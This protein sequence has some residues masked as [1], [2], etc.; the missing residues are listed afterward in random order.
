MSGEAQESVEGT[1][2]WG[3]LAHLLYLLVGGL[4]VFAFAWSLEPALEDQKEGLCRGL[5]PE[6]RELETPALV[7]QDLEGGSH[8]L[9]DLRGKFV[10]LNFW[11]TWCGPCVEE[12]PA[13]ARLAERM[14]ERDD[15]VVV[16]VSVDE[17]PEDIPPFLKQ[18][19]LGEVP[20]QV[21]WDPTGESHKSFGSEKLPDTYFIDEQGK[22]VAVFVN[23]RRWG[24]AEALRC[25]E[26]MVGNG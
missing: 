2:R 7:F 5:A 15:V 3:V 17:K 21:R 12:W 23:A 14:A 25:V 6:Q 1:D 4:L 26:G 24:S 16:A 22:I 18:M 10:V 20:V 11:A 9:E 8:T 13:L 19:Q